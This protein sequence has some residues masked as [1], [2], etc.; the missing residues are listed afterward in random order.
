MS[1]I[2]SAVS[3]AKRIAQDDSHGYDQ[4]DRWGNPDYDCSSL[5][6]SA[7]KQA[8]L[9][10]QSTYTGNMYGDFISNGFRDVT[11]QVN[12]YSGS[13]MQAGDVLLNEACH[14]CLYIG[15]GQVVHASISENG[16]VYA[17]QKG[18]QTGKEICIRSYWNYPWN[19]VLRYGGDASLQQDD[20]SSGNVINNIIDE[21]N[22]ILGKKTNVKKMNCQLPLLTIKLEKEQRDDVK[23]LQTLLIMRGY[24]CGGTE[25]DGYFG[26]ATKQAV[27]NLQTDKNLIIDGEAGSQVWTY[28]ITMEKG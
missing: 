6:I 28:L 11:S 9:P 7:F 10:L 15:N 21:V 18:D 1:I 3:W 12:L 27:I 17:T 13:G 22:E 19:Y 16:S 5:V 24:T 8:G 20:S 26:K 23:A 14:T 2:D 4:R 25:A